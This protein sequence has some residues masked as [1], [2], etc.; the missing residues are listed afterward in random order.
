MKSQE[1]QD[2]ENY[3]AD[4][5]K[6]MRRLG[7]ASQISDGSPVSPAQ[8]ALID[9][10]ASNPCCGVQDIANGLSL[11]PPTVS[12]SVR[13]MEGNGIVDRKPDPADARSVQF[14]L[15]KQ[16][17]IIYKRHKL[18]QKNI[19]KEL[20]SGLSQSERDTLI[21]LLDRALLSVENRLSKE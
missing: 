6:R 20:L 8:M 21:E 9:W 10:I 14:S 12:I 13:K 18:R 19:A 17:Q 15:T 1:N 7:V 3:F 4:L 11:T 16:G 5:L 2:S